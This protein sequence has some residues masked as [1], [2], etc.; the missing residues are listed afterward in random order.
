MCGRKLVDLFGPGVLR[1]AVTALP[2]KEILKL[3]QPFPEALASRLFIWRQQQAFLPASRRTKI[4]FRPATKAGAAKVA[5]HTP[6]R[7]G[8]WC[9]FRLVC[10]DTAHKVIVC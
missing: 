4:R 5:G 8:W 6:R 1:L 2:C 3:T 7:Y 9:R 10:C